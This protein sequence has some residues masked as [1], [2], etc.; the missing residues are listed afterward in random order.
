[1][2]VSEILIAVSHNYD[3]T[4]RTNTHRVIHLFY[5]YMYMYDLICIDM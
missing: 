1:M 2:V 4:C 5:I 3:G